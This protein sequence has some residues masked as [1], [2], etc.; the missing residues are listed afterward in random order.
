MKRWVWSV[1][2]WLLSVGTG[3]IRRRPPWRLSPE[4]WRAVRLSYS[5]YAED[6]I[7][8]HLFR[9][10]IQRGEPGVYVDVGAFDPFLFSNTLLLH[11]HGWRGLNVDPNREQ[12]ARF[13]R[14]RPADA[15]VC[16]AVSDA[17]R[18]VLYLEYRTGGTN[19]LVDP[20]ETDRVNPA[21]ELPTHT[22]PMTTVT[23]TELFTTHFPAATAIDFLN[24]DCEGL[25]LCVLRGLDWARWAPRVVAV[26]AYDDGARRSVTE[27]MTARG[28]SLVAQALLTLIFLR[29]PT[30]MSDLRPLA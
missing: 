28:Y 14:Y 25:D 18:P 1:L 19:R 30:R 12:V 24:I 15:S 10:Q 4:A 16:A 13:A 3:W 17:A 21:G 22:L 26:E 11:Q 5:H 8:L 2:A 6:L 9:E 27:W 29:T 20:A 7:V 23:L